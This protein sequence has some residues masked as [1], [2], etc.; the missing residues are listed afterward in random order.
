MPWSR[1]FDDPIQP[2]KGKPLVTLKDA[3]TYIMKLP[4]SKQQSPEWQAAGEALLMAAE[5]RGPLMHAHVGAASASRREYPPDR[6]F[7][8]QLAVMHV[9]TEDEALASNAA[10]IPA[11]LLAIIDQMPAEQQFPVGFSLRRAGSRPPPAGFSLMHVPFAG[12]WDWPL[13]NFN[14]AVVDVLDDLGEVAHIKPL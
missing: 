6:Q 2:P 9:I 1:R 10:V 8:Q 12:R 13:Q 3:A 4:E 7:Y 14:L 11:P 5:D